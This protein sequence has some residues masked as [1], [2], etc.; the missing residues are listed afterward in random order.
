MLYQCCNCIQNNNI[1]F[2]LI[3]YAQYLKIVI[4]MIFSVIGY[5]STRNTTLIFTLVIKH[6][7]ILVLCACVRFMTSYFLFMH[8]HIFRIVY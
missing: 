2:F 5:L 6:Y 8:K 3:S 4:L 7:L 1:Y